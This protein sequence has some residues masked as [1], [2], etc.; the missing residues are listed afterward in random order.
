MPLKISNDELPALNLTPMIDV[1]F[2]LII[3]FMVGTKFAEEER[4]LDLQIPSVG[5]AAPVLASPKKR[6]V[7]VLKNGSVLLDDRVVSVHE[8]TAELRQSRRDRPN[9]GV[10]IRGDAESPYQN[11]ATVFSACKSAGIRNMAVSVKLER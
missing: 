2:L 5:Q 6:I 7:N 10:T 8:L 9:V 3:F 1:V 4:K 11:I